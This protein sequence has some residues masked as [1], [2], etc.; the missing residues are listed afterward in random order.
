VRM[1]PVA[2]P[3]SAYN[4]CHVVYTLVSL[5]H[6]LSAQDQSGTGPT[7]TFVNRKNVDGARRTSTFIYVLTILLVH[8]Q[9]N[10]FHRRAH[11]AL[12]VSRRPSRISR[13]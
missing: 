6:W 4:V 8:N 5:V 3:N 9:H 10:G 2:A 1:Q 12:F 7:L 13:A 11:T